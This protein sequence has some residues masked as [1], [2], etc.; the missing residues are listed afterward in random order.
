MRLW[1]NGEEVNGGRDCSPAEGYLAL[2]AE[3]AEV[4]FRNIRVRRLP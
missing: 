4:S 1:V 3:G 2:E